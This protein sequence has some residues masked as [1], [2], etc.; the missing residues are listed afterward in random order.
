MEGQNLSAYHKPE[1]FL[2][3]INDNLTS[4]DWEQNFNGMVG[5]YR[6]AKHHPEFLASEYKPL[7]QHLMNHVRNLRSQVSL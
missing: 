7:L 3:R 2:D 1:D 4:T 5:V 6:L